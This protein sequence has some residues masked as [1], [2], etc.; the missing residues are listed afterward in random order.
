MTKGW[1]LPDNVSPND[2]EAT[3]NK[4]EKER[5]FVIKNDITGEYW[6]NSFGW[7]EE[8]FTLFSEEEKDTFLYIPLDSEWELFHEEEV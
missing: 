7:V 6:S 2:P 5:T 3:W 1:N 4:K 8:G